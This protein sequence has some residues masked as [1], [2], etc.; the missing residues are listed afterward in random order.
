VKYEI[1]QAMPVDAVQVTRVH[2]RSRAAYYA[3]DLDPVDASRDRYPMWR[4]AL[5]GTDIWCL[6]AVQGADVVGFVAA[7]LADRGDALTELTS[8][9]VDPDRFGIGIGSAL[10]RRFLEVAPAGTAELEVWD[11]NDRAKRFYTLRGWRPTRRS[12]AGV[13]SKSFV[14]WTLQIG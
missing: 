10:Y 1:R 8:L 4:E 3:D 7:H 5:T 9:Y 6:V 2:E 14:T 11:G 12:R 13:A